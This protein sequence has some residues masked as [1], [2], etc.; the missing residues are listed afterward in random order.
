M[1][2][3]DKNKCIGCGQCVSIAPEIFELGDDGKADIK[4]PKACEDNKESCKKAADECPVNAI[5][6]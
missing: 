2:N 6:L 1:V 4:D 3:I 5:E